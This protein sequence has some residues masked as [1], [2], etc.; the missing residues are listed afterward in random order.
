M[1]TMELSNFYCEPEE[2]GCP[3]YDENF[4]C[5]REMDLACLKKWLMK[6]TKNDAEGA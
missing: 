1:G 4:E 6:G 3:D 5:T 2:N